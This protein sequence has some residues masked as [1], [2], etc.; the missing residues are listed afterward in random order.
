M[1][2]L[3][4]RPLLSAQLTIESRGESLHIESSS[5]VY[6]FTVAE[7]SGLDDFLRRLD[8]SP[9]PN[10]IPD[11]LRN[12]LVNVVATLA[13]DG[14]AIDTDAIVRAETIDSFLNAYFEEAEFWAREIVGAPFYQELLSGTLRD[15]QVLGWGIEF[16]HYVASANRH[17][18]IGISEA[19]DTDLRRK[20]AKHYVEEAD[21]DEI[22]LSGLHQ[23]GLPPETVRAARPLPATQALINALVEMAA[24]DTFAYLATFG[25]MQQSRATKQPSEIAFFYDGLA[26]R[27]PRASGMFEGFRKHAMLDAGLEHNELILDWAL[28]RNGLTQSARDSIVHGLRQIARFFI[29][30]H[31]CILDYYGDQGAPQIRRGIDIR[32]YLP[33]VRS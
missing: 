33:S 20:L 14:L 15:A 26:Q 7:A 32:A 1:N 29:L 19:A 9:A 21:H 30:F 18:A 16:T 4:G 8:G 10:D 3:S 23:C 2:I 28:R 5:N 11:A 13:A 12:A 25:V 24:T 27:Y 22:F 31:E 17:M 6:D